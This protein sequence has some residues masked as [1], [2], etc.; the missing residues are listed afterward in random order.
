MKLKFL[1][2]ETAAKNNLIQLFSRLK[3]RCCREEPA[4]EFEDGFIEEKMQDV[5]I[6]FLQTQTDQ[7]IDLQDH[8]AR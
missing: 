5:L 4:L 1:K 6:Q 7:L 2:I 3:Q 8:L